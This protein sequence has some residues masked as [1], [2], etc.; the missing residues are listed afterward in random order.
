MSSG[1]TNRIAV[2]LGR[3][4][5]EHTSEKQWFVMRDLKRA[6]AKMPAYR[7]LGEAGFSVFTPLTERIVTRGARR[8]REQVPF[9]PDLLFVLSDRA[10][11]DPVVARTDTLQYRYVK[12]AP[13]RTPMT[14]PAVDMARFIAAVSTFRAPRYL[15]PQEVTA[16][17]CGARVRMVCAG[18]LNGYEGLL[19][20]VKGSGKKR[21]LVQLPGLLAAA[22]EIAAPDY[23]QLLP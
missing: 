22:I 14:V 23:I 16:A 5:M 3:Y 10:A 20:R 15:H 2:S 9:M 11:L 17:M 7:A 8:V 18:P 21:L 1:R 13:Y 19:L 12:G 4:P 6:N